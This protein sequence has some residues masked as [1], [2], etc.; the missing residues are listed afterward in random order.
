MLTDLSIIIPAY[1]EARRIGATLA[2]LEAYCQRAARR[3]VQ[4]EVIV[5]CDGCQDD[6]RQVAET[7]ASRF[8]LRVIAYDVNRGKGYAVRRG[9]AASRGELVLFMDADGSTPADEIDRLAK[10]IRQGHTDVVV[11][12]RRVADARV[13]VA[14][15]LRRRMLGRVFAW[16][17]RVLLGL[18]VRDTQC[19]FKVFGGAIARELF[20]RMRC[21]GFA[22]DLELLVLARERG[23]RVWE[24]GVAWR[25]V[26]GSTVHPLRDGLKMLTAA[27]QLRFRHGLHPRRADGAWVPRRL[28]PVPGVPKG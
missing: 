7:A 12:S 2:S 23:I 4:S 8:P 13:E 20:G 27:W 24:C 15:T 18:P 17:T 22:F 1:N 3:G 21:D 19:G 9:V 16:H 11:G 5:V 6:T 10:P 28:V 26:A 14:Q 25:E